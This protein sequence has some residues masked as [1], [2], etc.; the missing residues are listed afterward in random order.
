VILTHLKGCARTCRGQERAGQ[1]DFATTV[2]ETRARYRAITEIWSLAEVGASL[3]LGGVMDIGPQA[4]RASR[5]E[6]LEPET[7]VDIG[8]TLDALSRLAAWVRHHDT[9]AL[10]ELASSIEL[11]EELAQDL[12]LSFDSEG[13]LSGDRYPTLAALRR[14]H[15]QLRSDIRRTLE[16]ML[17][18][19]AILAVLQDRFI[20]DRNGRFVLPVLTSARKSIGIVHDTSQSGETAY[21]EPAAVVEPQ[22]ELK[23][24]GAEIRREER[25]ILAQLSAAVGEASG[26]IHAALGAAT[27][28]DLA[29]ARATLGTLMNA[30]IPTVGEGGVVQ[31]IQAR[32]PVLVLR[33][34][35]VVAN[36]LRLDGQQP[37][38]VLSGPNAGGKTV[39]LKTIG[40]ATLMVRAGIPIPASDRSRVDWMS[41]VRALV[42][43]QQ[44]VSDDLSTFSA[45]LLGV[46]LALES[47]GPGSLLL[48]DEL[49]MGTDP[50]Q[51]SAL[52]QAIVEA[53]IDSGARVVLTTHHAALKAMAAGD[54]RWSLAG[55]VFADGRPTYRIQTGR[56]GHSH[57]LA[58]ARQMA[59]P[60]EVL[61][62]AR[63]LLDADTRR[64][65]DL[66]SELET[67]REAVHQQILSQAESGRRLAERERRLT[68]REERLI[69]RRDKDEAEARAAFRAQLAEHE[70]TLKSLI[71]DLQAGPT[72]KQAAVVLD[73]VKAAR[74]TAAPV[75]PR[76][77]APVQAVVPGDRVRV[78]G[79]TGEV[80]SVKGA[81][82]QVQIRGMR[83]EVGLEELEKAA[84]IQRRTGASSRPA[85]VA[86]LGPVGIRTQSN[87]LDMRGMRVEEAL[88]A[89]ADFLDRSVLEHQ[90]S[91]FL[92]H[93]HGT[94]AL[95]SA[96]RQ[97][98]PRCAHARRWHKGGPEE[99]GDAFTVVEI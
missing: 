30:R 83:V 28:L 22:N 19:P 86:D 81:K 76:P 40:L 29:G 36:D 1:A 24:V 44:A 94:G 35:P 89:V 54:E 12:V 11:P 75:R 26:A 70:R 96:L 16:A 95:K 17:A 57:A 9:P 58:V 73:E 67:E 33:E 2:E 79:G 97:W 68:E 92:L 20:T 72:L 64:M 91:V 7:L 80:V 87:T 52:A 93:G 84:P 56:A 27:E 66:L 34:V 31:L 14:R 65:D 23:I 62:R 38:L 85:P 51:G 82:I 74:A 55:A 43:D 77:A 49:G 42:G 39:G 32:H 3:P 48:L 69:A 78:L 4:G 71:A 45:Q 63:G 15:A 8:A 18:D 88:D 25:R 46:R 41:Q 50:A 6:V 59:L 47:G 5:G 37:G 99:G 61:E 21:V 60:A 10:L 53:L 90:A 98:L 13:R